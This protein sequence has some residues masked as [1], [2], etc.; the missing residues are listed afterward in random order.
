MYPTHT[1]HMSLA[2]KHCTLYSH[3]Y[4]VHFIWHRVFSYLNEIIQIIVQDWLI[5]TV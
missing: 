3:L 2:V 1:F 5:H 4:T